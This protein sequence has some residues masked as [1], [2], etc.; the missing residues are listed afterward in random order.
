MVVCGA[1]LTAQEKIGFTFTP[2]LVLGHLIAGP[3]VGTNVGP[4][5]VATHPSQTQ[6]PL[7]TLIQIC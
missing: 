7:C 5:S 3:A 2:L 6:V 4:L 1:L